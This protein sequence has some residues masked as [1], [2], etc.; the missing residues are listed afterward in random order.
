MSVNYANCCRN[1]LPVVPRATVEFGA[2][3]AR[4]I[5][6]IL[7]TGTATRYPDIRFI[8]SHGGG[9][10]PMLTGR[11]DD[12]TKGVKA[13]RDNVPEGVPAQI[14]KIYVDTA[15]AFHPGAMAATL[16]VL[17]PDHVLYGSDFPYSSS[18]EAIAGLGANKLDPRVLAGIERGNA[19]ALFPSLRG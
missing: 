6:S 17:P 7:F 14:A 5:G 1:I 9:T 15:G 3:T 4:A 16:A 10:I 12:L 13:L 11:I 19:L 8:F 18:S 2:D